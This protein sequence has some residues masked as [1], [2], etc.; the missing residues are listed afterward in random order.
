MEATYEFMSF[1]EDLFNADYT[2]NY[3]TQRPLTMFFSKAS[4]FEAI[5]SV[6]DGV[7]RWS[8]L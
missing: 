6:A 7:V 4:P 5:A 1:F 2:Q 8:C 3:T